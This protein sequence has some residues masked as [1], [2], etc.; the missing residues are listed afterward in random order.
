MNL[1]NL[2]LIALRQLG[3]N[4]TRTFLTTLGIIIGVSSVIA[5]VAIGNGSKENIQQ[6]I[7]SLGTN[8][9][10]VFP[11][12]SARGG[13]RMDAGSSQKLTMQDEQAMKNMCQ[14]I[15]YISPILQTRVQAVCGALN[16]RTMVMGV[17]PDYFNIRNLKVVFGESFSMSDNNGLAKVCVVGQTV[18]KELFGE[19]AMPVGQVIRLNNIPYRIIGVTEKKG[20]NTFGQDQDDIVIAP[21]STV[22]KRMM[23]GGTTNGLQQILI[24]AKSENEIEATTGEISQILRE[25]HRIREGEDDDFNVRTQSEFSAIMSSTTKIMSVLLACIAGISLLVG[26]IGIMNI[27]LVSVTERTRE[28][29]IRIAIGAKERVIMMQFLIESI[30]LSLAG[31]IIG[32]IL[33]CSIAILVATFA[34]WSVSISFQSVSLAFIFSTLIGVFFGW[35]PARKAARLNPIDAL[36]YE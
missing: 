3:R 33:G 28:I 11:G 13:V 15:R 9:I 4:R 5:M 6:S 10:I 7:A 2:F 20:Q 12:S 14:K 29:G 17:Y 25:R 16:H 19:G 35:Y 26:G 21:F 24:S 1:W 22:Q 8:V 30:L 36:R 32:I 27:M 18:I 23:S 34:G 31:G